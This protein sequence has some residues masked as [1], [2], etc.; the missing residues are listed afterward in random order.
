MSSGD[1]QNSQRDGS[2]ER[3][4]DRVISVIL[5]LIWLVAVFIVYRS[6]SDIPLSMLIVATIF[7]IMLVPAMKELVKIIDRRVKIQLGLIE[8][9]D[10]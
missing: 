9:A 10:E 1:S 8:P 5:A 3:F 6:E 2:R 7:F 4:H